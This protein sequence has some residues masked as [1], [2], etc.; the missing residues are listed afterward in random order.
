[1][2]DRGFPR[3]IFATS[4]DDYN[5]TLKLEESVCYHAFW[6]CCIFMLYLFFTLATMILIILLSMLGDE[7]INA[8]NWYLC[9]KCYW[10]LK[11]LI[12]VHIRLR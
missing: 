5:N 1:M 10:T 8:I 3:I 11:M 7:Y 2:I 9:T 12:L 6:K 4:N